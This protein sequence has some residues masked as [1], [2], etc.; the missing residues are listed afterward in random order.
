MSESEIEE[1]L[2][3]DA[4]RHLKLLAARELVRQEDFERV[5]RLTADLLSAAPSD[6]DALRL[7]VLAACVLGDGERARE[8]ASR[9]FPGQRASLQKRCDEVGIGL[10]P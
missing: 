4:P 9:L 10:D 8:H 6:A 3:P 1:A 2:A 7:G 5:Q